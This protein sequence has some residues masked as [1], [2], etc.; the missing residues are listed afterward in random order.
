[1]RRPRLG[2][3]VSHPIQYQVP[4]YRR[5]AARGVVHPVVFFLTD[6]GLKPSLD[7]G[8]GRPV[9]Y[10]IPLLGGYDYHVL[11]N[12]SPMPTLVRPWGV[13][14]PGLIRVLQPS[15]I[16]AILVHGYSHLSSW[17][18]YATASARHIPFL[19]RGESHPDRW[20]SA[21]IRTMVKRRILSPLVRNAG[22]CLPIGK[23][24]REFYLS[25]GADPA[26]LFFCPYSVDTE[27]FRR[28]GMVGRADRERRLRR[29]GLRPELPLVL[30]AAKLQPW[31]RPLDVIM[32][33]ERAEC[34]AN[35]IVIGDGPIRDEVGRLVAGRPWVRAL[36]FVNQGEIGEWFGAADVF[37][38]PSD[39]EPW[40]VVVNEAMAA[41]A[42][43]IV[44]DRVGCG[45]DLVTPDVGWVYPVG[46]VRALARAIE[47]ACEPDALTARRVAAQ[48]RSGEYGVDASAEGIEQAVRS[49]T[50]GV[51]D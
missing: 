16:D 4:L 6:Y 22:A 48:R 15:E 47:A 2:I 8:F 24:N 28:D 29:L 27:R 49:L 42:V 1:M 38:L 35:V 34:E 17:L 12:W 3:V 18:G 23:E 43:P 26:K 51:G 45:P 31:K 30:F 9:Q 33:V 32:A 20:P 10:D 46:N 37:V 50:P 5:L 40:G 7:V 41:G 39:R 36:G 44:S 25:Y 14:N 13:V 19:L 11:R 21:T